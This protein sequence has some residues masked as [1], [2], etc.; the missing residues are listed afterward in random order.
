MSFL[1]GLLGG[2]WKYILA[3][4][5]IIAGVLTVLFQAKKAGKDEVIAK[6]QEKELENV[7]TAA[8]VDQDVAATKPAARR[9]RLLDKWTRD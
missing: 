1:L 6:T 5:G 4:L 3:A 8:K 7:Q 9:K 2:A